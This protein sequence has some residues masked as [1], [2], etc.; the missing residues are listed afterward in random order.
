VS[1]RIEF[2]LKHRIV[3][4]SFGGTVTEQSLR[5]GF[6]DAINFV[7]ENGME[8]AIL[9]FSA[10]E[11]FHVSMDF[12]RNYVNTR[13]I[14]APDKPRISVAPQPVIYGMHRAFSVYAES[15]GVFPEV[16]RT[17]AE[18]Y[19]FLKLDSPLFGSQPWVAQPDS[20]IAQKSASQL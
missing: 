13:E 14:V 20:G 1:H 11:H 7:R 2:E 10:V 12:V 8:G 5:S 15:S 18:A 9:D 4:L 17:M 3:L 19:Q 6:S 16:V